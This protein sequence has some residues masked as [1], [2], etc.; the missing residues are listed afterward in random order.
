MAL[1]KKNL[2]ISKSRKNELAAIPLDKIII[3]QAY[4]RAYLVRKKLLIP[5]SIYQTKIWRKNRSW[6][7]NGKHNEC[8]LYQIRQIELIMKK[9]LKKT[10][11][12]INLESFDI[13]QSKH[14]MIHNDG[15]EWTENFDGKANQCYFN[16]KFVCDS[17]GA[18]TRTL[19]L[20]YN[21]IKAQLEYLKKHHKTTKKNAKDISKNIY[22]INI[23]DG[24]ASYHNM[25]KFKFL[26][27]KEYYK[28]IRKFIFVGSLHD[29]QNS[30]EYT[31]L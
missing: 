19:I 24:D 31:Q 17:G 27:N 8:E 10:N 3:I 25:P 20:T 23:L 4:Y 18:Q 30:R 12:R 22:F 21:F 26:L 29:F 1:I 2:K 5:A 28:K 15:Y 13:L 7:K 9:P 11:D 16:L 6:Y 14:P